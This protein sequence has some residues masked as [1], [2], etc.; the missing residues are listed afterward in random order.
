MT[1]ALYL[2][3]FQQILHQLENGNDMPAFLGMRLIRWKKL[4]QHQNDRGE[5][6]LR[7]IIEKGVLSAI[8]VIAIGVDNGFGK[9]L[10]VLLRLGSSRK[11]LGIFS[12]DIHVAVDQCQQVVAV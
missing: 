12:C 3:G 7:R 4:R 9:D 8:A 2:A 11:V 10:G 1:L 5:Q 6:S